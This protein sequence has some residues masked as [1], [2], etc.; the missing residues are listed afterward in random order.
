MQIN[1]RVHI[2]NG[3]YDDWQLFYDSYKVVR[4]KYIADEKVLRVSDNEASV[5]FEVRDLSGLTSLSK[6]Q[7]V[8]DGEARLGIEVTIVQ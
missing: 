1:A 3:S 4:N 7:F 5:M 8:L 2:K 6:S